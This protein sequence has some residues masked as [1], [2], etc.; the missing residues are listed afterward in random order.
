MQQLFLSTP[1]ARRATHPVLQVS[2]RSMYFYP[3]PP[4]GERRPVSRFCAVG[5]PI[6]IHALR[7]ESDT[8]EHRQSGRHDDFYP[9]PPRGERP[10]S[11][12]NSP[13]STSISIHAL[14]EES[15]AESIRWLVRRGTFLST[16]SA[17]RATSTGTHRTAHRPI[18]I[19]ALREESDEYPEWCTDNRLHFY[20]RPPRG[21]RP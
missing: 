17:R 21:E 8:T 15:D 19:H 7:E 2:G 6:S 12:S 1:S 9:R 18:S 16:P 5:Y 20:P 3:R 4:R 13:S 14:R 10:V 11:V